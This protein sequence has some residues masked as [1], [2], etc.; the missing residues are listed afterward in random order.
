M[1][2]FLYLREN[3]IK[4]IIE[5]ML[6][7]YT[8]S[9]SDPYEILKKNSFG[10]IPLIIGVAVFL[11]SCDQKEKPKSDLQGAGASTSELAREAR[12]SS[13]TSKAGLI[14]QMERL[15]G[16]QLFP[17]VEGLCLIPR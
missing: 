6:E 15:P 5:L 17:T 7:A 8:E 1:N 3:N 9:Y 11:A 13:W 2:D 16:G 10:K 14:L 12:F 4:E